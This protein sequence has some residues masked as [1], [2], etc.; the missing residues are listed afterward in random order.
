MVQADQ[1]D[2][3]DQAVGAQVV[4]QV[5]MTVHGTQITTIMVVKEAEVT[6]QIFFSIHYKLTKSAL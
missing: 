4:A 3:A 2:Q 1:A 6:S 5:G